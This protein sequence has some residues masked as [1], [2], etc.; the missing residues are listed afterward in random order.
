MALTTVNVVR[1]AQW[2][3]LTATDNGQAYVDFI[4]SIPAQDGICPVS[5]ALN[6]DGSV[7][8]TTQI[9]GQENV[10]TMPVDRWYSYDPTMP[11]VRGATSYNDLGNQPS[12]TGEL[13]GLADAAFRASFG[14]VNQ[15]P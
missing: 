14:T 5:A 4:N 6:Q 13:P 7:N 2:F 12:S 8:L 3:F 11:V 10:L 9:W 1:T 15:V